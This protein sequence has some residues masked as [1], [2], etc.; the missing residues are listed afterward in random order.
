M[1]HEARP[2][3]GHE[4]YRKY[5]YI[6]R[7]FTHL[8]YV[9]ANAEHLL[10]WSLKPDSSVKIRTLREGSFQVHGPKLFNCMPAKI[11]NIKKCSVAEFKAKLDV[12]LSRVPDE[13]KVSGYIPSACDQ[14]REKPTNA[15]VDQNRG[16]EFEFE[17]NPTTQR[18]HGS[19]NWE[20]NGESGNPPFLIL[21]FCFKLVLSFCFS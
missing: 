21:N 16:I 1:R 4:C 10:D 8:R 18:S 19:W 7:M 5:I 9:Y 11:R 20:E 12:V 14:F 3:P 2:C 17:K 13:P 6:R 15:I